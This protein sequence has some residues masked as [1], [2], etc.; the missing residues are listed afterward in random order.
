M[1]AKRH[2]QEEIFT[3]KLLKIAC[4]ASLFCLSANTAK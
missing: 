3:E 4:G 2:L 1:S